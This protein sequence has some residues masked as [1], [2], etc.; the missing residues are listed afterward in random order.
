M[1]FVFEAKDGARVKRY[2]PPGARVPFGKRIRVK[3]KTYRRVPT[4]P[5]ASVQQ[6]IH[7]R[8]Q[9]LPPNYKY[10]REAG[11]PM[12]AKGE[13]QFSSRAQIDRMLSLAN[14]AG[15]GLTY[16]EGLDDSSDEA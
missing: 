8:S 11:V 2:F 10:A 13:P 5:E 9:T 1:I 12:N 3:G 15:E 7:F 4:V 16:N 6:D 14:A